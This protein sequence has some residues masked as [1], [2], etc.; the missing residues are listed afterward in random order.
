MKKRLACALQE[1]LTKKPFPKITVGE[2]VDLCGVNRKTFYYHFSDIHALLC[3]MFGE[4]FRELMQPYDHL[5]DYIS[6]ANTVMDYVEKNEVIFRNLV[7]TMGEDGLMRA[8]NEDIRS[9]QNRV[10]S[11]FEI[12]YNVSFEE[13]FRSFLVNFLTEAIVGVLMDWIRKRKYNS[14]E[15]TIEY[16]RDIFLAAIPGLIQNHAH[17]TEQK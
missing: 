14:R 1:I 2:I 3:W 12:Y 11:G 4:E 10:V 16:L 17:L 8:L 13:E 9:L 5:T 7:D 6:L 15:R